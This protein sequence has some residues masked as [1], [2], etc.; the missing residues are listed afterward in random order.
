MRLLYVFLAILIV[1]GVFLI[2]DPT[3]AYFLGDSESYLATSVIHWIP[4]DR[5]FLYGLLIQPYRV[6]LSLT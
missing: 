2:L 4:P 3:P 5:S 6:S 1:K